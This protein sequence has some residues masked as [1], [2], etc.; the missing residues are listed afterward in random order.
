[1]KLQVEY[2]DGEVLEFELDVTPGEWNRRFRNATR[3]GG[4][5]EI[6]NAKGKVLAINPRQVKA[7]RYDAEPRGK[8]EPV[9][10]RPV[11]R[12]S[13]SSGGTPARRSRS[14]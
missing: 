14:D 6:E 7:V 2:L 5:V 12:R 9:H 10:L 4:L 1:M 11:S 3:R 8:A 13:P